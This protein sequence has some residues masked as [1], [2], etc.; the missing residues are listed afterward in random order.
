MGIR[1]LAEQVIKNDGAQG[2]RIPVSDSINH[3]IESGLLEEFVKEEA[4][5]EFD[6]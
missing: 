3:R 6:A 5:P 1:L 4:V 2:V